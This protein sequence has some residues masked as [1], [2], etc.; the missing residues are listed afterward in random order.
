MYGR[1]LLQVL[2]ARI[3][4]AQGKRVAIVCSDKKRRNA[5]R[6]QFPD[7]AECF[8]VPKKPSRLKGRHD[9]IMDD[10]LFLHFAKNDFPA[11][12]SQAKGER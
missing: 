8:I 10:P 2:E 7:I 4:K 3:L 1:T 5:L 9:W 11:P 12:Q 6:R